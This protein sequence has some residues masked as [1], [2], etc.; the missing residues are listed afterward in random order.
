MLKA[1][2]VLISLPHNC[3]INFPAV[4]GHGNNANKYI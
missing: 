4:V 3:F 2:E 1:E